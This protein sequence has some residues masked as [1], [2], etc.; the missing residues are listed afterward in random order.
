MPEMDGRH[1][2]RALRAEAPQTPIVMLTG[3]GRMMKEDG[4]TV[5]EVNAVLSKPPHMEELNNLLSQVTASRN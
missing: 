2:A 4:E 5:P 1:V 3:W